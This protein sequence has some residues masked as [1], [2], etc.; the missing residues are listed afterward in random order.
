MNQTLK[1]KAVK[2]AK[3]AG[4]AVLGALATYSLE[5][6]SSVDFGEY[7]V[8]VGAVMSI[9]ANAIRQWVDYMINSEE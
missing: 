6:T 1:E 7:A 9:V 5:I 8:I 3:G 4:I 2:V